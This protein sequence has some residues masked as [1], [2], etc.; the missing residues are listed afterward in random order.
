VSDRG[1]E[2]PQGEVEEALAAIWAEVLGV[3]RI[4]RNDNFFELGG[5]SISAVQLVTRARRQLRVNLAVRDVFENFTL[6]KMALGVRMAGE[7]ALL[8]IDCFIDNLEGV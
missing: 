4:G 1:Y 6:T 3:E 8:E 7:E 2:A 5:D